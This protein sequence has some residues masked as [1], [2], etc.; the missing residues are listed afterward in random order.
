MERKRR[1]KYINQD[2]DLQEINYDIDQEPIIISKTTSDIILNR[3]PNK[4]IVQ[5]NPANLMALY[6]FY[7]YTAK[8]QKANKAKATT[9][10]AAKGLKW[11]EDKVR[12]TKK[13]LIKLGLIEDVRGKRGKKGKFGACYINVKFIWW[14]KKRIN[15]FNNPHPLDLPQGGKVDTVANQEGNALNTDNLNALSTDTLNNNTLLH[16]VKVLEKP[17]KDDINLILSFWNNLPKTTTHSR[18]NKQGQE[19]K[20]YKTISLHLENLLSGKPLVRKYDGTPTKPYADFLKENNIH[21]S[22]H[23]KTWTVDEIKDILQAFYDEQSVKATKFPLDTVF[24]NIF[25]KFRGGAF[26]WFMYYASQQIDD[27]DGQNEEEGQ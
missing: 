20:T 27:Y 18:L 23:T 21:S 7:Y 17:Y 26:S 22:L 12:Q 1:E 3:D 8:W 4:G 5:E 19:T 25:A 6:W 16:K 2:N 10:Y 13:Q 14:D 24:W 9:S 11:G 15:K